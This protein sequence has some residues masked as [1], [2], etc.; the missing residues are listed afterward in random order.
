MEP[1]QPTGTEGA[2]PVPGNGRQGR[3]REGR[4]RSGEV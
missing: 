1:P 4:P 3:H 2:I